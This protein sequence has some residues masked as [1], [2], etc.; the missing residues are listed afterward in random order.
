MDESKKIIDGIEIKYKLKKRKYDTQ[1]LIIVFSGF[2]ASGT[3][4]TYDFESALQECPAT[5]IWIKDE[6]YGNCTYYICK[7]MNFNISEAI[8]KFIMNSLNELALSKEQCTL[9]GFSKGGSSALYF[10]MK[11]GFKNIL[12]SVPQLKIGSYV[13]GNWRQVAKHMIGESVSDDRVSALDSL[14]PN[15]INNDSDVNKN[16]YLLTS[17]SDTQFESEIKPFLHEFIKYKNFNL[18][19][20]NSLL[21]TEHNQVTAYHVPLILAICYS[22]SQGATPIYGCC[23]LKGDRKSGVVKGGRECIAILKKMRVYNNVIFPEGVAVIKG[24]PCAE[25]Q[26]IKI[27]MVFKNLESNYECSY[28]IAKEHRPILSRHLYDSGYVNYSKGWFC[29]L[30]KEVLDISDILPG[31]Y[32]ISLRINCLGIVKTARLRLNGL[33]LEDSCFN[34]I[35]YFFSDNG[36]LNFVKKGNSNYS[37]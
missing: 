11:F 24:V 4:F 5:T 14:L 16:I 25:Y 37:V 29:T 12:A 19:Y 21:V 28:F 7:D 6:F 2:G 32:Q 36:L 23:D 18:F 8:Y 20:A 31:T 30:R 15:T 1:H 26:D 10:G 27:E 3:S 22:L 33:K 35:F 9:I 17:H 34:D 13:K